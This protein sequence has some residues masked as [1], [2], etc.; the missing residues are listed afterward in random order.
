MRTII[1]VCYNNVYVRDEQSE[2]Y[3]LKN[4]PNYFLGKNNYLYLV[5]SYGNDKET[6]T[7][8]VDLIIF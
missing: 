6:Y 7:S 2:I 5:Y 3:K 1:I 4:T 8:E